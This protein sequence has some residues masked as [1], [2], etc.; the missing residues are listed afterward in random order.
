[1]RSGVH[2]RTILRARLSSILWV[3]LLV[4]GLLVAAIQ[5]PW[6]V[7]D[8][9]AYLDL[10][11]NL[12]GPGFGN[13]R[14]A[15]FVLNGIRPPGYPWLLNILHVRIGLPLW[16]IIAVQLGL[17]L[18]TIWLFAFK[19]I[20]ADRHRV[21]FLLLAIVYFYPFFYV[22]MI[23]SEAWATLIVALIVVVLLRARERIGPWL[24]A[25]VLIGL[26][27]LVRTDILPIGLAL[28]AV[29]FVRL[30]P[31]KAAVRSLIAGC[32]A[33]LIV[34]PYMLWNQ[35]N[36]GQ[37]TPKPPTATVGLS[38]WLASWESRL[39]HEDLV[40]IEGGPPT[41]TAIETGYLQ[42]YRDTTA[43]AGGG[44]GALSD[45]FKKVALARMKADPLDAVLHIAN[46][47]WRLFMT[48]EYP[49][50]WPFTLPLHILSLGVIGLAV[51]GAATRRLSFVPAAILLAVLIPH[52]PLHS[53]ARYT[54]PLRP[55]LLFYASF[56]LATLFQRFSTARTAAAGEAARG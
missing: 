11:R 23:L 4:E 54:A 26:G 5:H 29:A 3:A 44:D 51:W 49:L 20:E 45:E 9:R 22:T 18:T 42:E 30:K 25:G 1:M 43:R 55:I 15:D 48:R 46:G 50:P 37:F 6:I 53:E 41:R 31:A 17:Y 16:T 24:L 52:L 36:F 32:A 13:E 40:T 39:S 2:L 35:A 38:L 10:A 27:G 14:G 56:I 28:V 12:S 33:I 7:D 34:L 19:V 21:A 8:S 47:T